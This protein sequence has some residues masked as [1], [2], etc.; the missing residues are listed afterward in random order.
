MTKGGTRS[1]STQNSVS[2]PE[3]GPALWMTMKRKYVAWRACGIAALFSAF[4]TLMVFPKSVSGRLSRASRSS[5]N[6]SNCKSHIKSWRGRTHDQ[7]RGQLVENIRQTK[8]QGW[9]IDRTQMNDRGNEYLV[10]EQYINEATQARTTR[11]VTN[12]RRQSENE[13]AR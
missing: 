10:D 12:R 7:N 6:S 3:T 4:H 11:T 9:E 2:K 8:E 5:S 13:C 1:L